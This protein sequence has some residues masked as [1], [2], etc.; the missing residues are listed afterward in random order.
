MGG[1]MPK[2]SVI[3]AT[4]NCHDTLRDSI[5]SILNQTYKDWEFIICDDC[6][7]DDTYKILK[8]YEDKYPEQIKI[9]KNDVNSKLSFSLNHC[10]K[11]AKGE[12]IARMD[13]DDISLPER[14]EKQVEFLDEHSE[15]SVVGSAML[16]FDENGDKPVRYY[17]E[18]PGKNDML[19]RSPFPHATIMMRKT[20]Y[21]AVGGYT[22]S[23]RTT[24]AQDYDMWFRF[25]ALGLKGYNLQEPLYRVLEDDNAIR[26]R[27]FQSRC[28]EVQ[29]KLIGYKMLHYP[30]YKYIFAFKP[31]LSALI[32]VGIMQKY[33]Q[34]T[35]AK[36]GEN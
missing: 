18:E 19:S 21:D 7:V 17:K 1:I 4:F 14:L 3:M 28:Y 9:L 22:V 2:V 29:T 33:H 26:R 20:A 30:V 24:R 8:E 34:I 25:F 35:D 16:P 6:S 13:G 5:D 32:P 10:L 15:Y 23:K 36:S 31:I 27:T 12:Y 11:Y